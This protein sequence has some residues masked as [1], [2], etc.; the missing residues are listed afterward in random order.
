MGTLID[1][2]LMLAREGQSIGETESIELAEMVQECCECVPTEGATLEVDDEV[3]LTGDWSPVQQLFENLLRNAVEHGG[4]DV[5]DRIGIL[6]N[7]SGIYIEDDGSGIPE[8]KRDQIFT[9]GYST[10]ERGS[11]FGL[12]IVQQIVDAHGWDIHV[13]ESSTGGARFEITGMDIDT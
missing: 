4:R 9:D 3:V 10:G 6:G 7:D 8:A 11:G 12:T 5:T 2:L 1:D 13:T